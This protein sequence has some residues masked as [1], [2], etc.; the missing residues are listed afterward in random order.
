LAER[1]EKDRGTDLNESAQ[2]KEAKHGA[3]LATNKLPTQTHRLKSTQGVF[4]VKRKS[5]DIQEDDDKT[6]DNE[7]DETDELKDPQDG[8]QSQQTREISTFVTRK[9]VLQVNV[10]VVAKGFKDSVKGAR[11]ERI[12][13][14]ETEDEF[15]NRGPEQVAP[16][17]LHFVIINR[18]VIVVRTSVVRCLKEKKKEGTVK[19]KRDKKSEC[20]KQTRLTA[21]KTIMN[22]NPAARVIKPI[23]KKLPRLNFTKE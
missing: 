1:K 9:Q 18:I 22:K 13:D 20:N 15:D 12:Q 17:D 11:I 7:E 19:N 8:R 2:K 4:L 3:E 5:E 14:E 10:G 6:R 23:K 16:V 21:V